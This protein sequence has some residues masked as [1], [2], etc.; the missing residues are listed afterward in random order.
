[1]TNGN[2]LKAWR[3]KL[4]FE[5]KRQCTAPKHGQILIVLAAIEAEPMLFPLCTMTSGSKFAC[6]LFGSLPLL[7]LVAAARR[8]ALH[9]GGRAA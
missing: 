4:P 9:A 1:M 2:S 8:S 6:M 3:K 5:E 7:R